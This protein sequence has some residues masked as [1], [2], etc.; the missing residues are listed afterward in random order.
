MSTNLAGT[1]KFGI[2]PENVFG[3][4][5]WVGGRYSVWSAVGGLPLSL[6]FGYEAFEEFL[7]GGRKIDD[8]VANTK[9][10][11]ANIP[12]MLGLIGFYNTFSSEIT[13][14]AI[15]PYCQALSKFPNH[16]QQLDME[17]NGKSV[18]LD[19]QFL[20]HSCSP[21]VFG[22]P[23]TNGQHGFYQLI[24]Q[25]RSIACEFIGFAKSQSEIKLEGEKHSNHEELMS[26][27]FAQVSFS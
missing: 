16:I 8:H 18:S 27:F 14:R 3:F 22:E 11:R 9:D 25:G 24:H 19:N 4:W 7:V 13:T 20:P 23:G 17:S 12:I 1:S 15:L 26:N 6:V 21:I 5:D 2:D 10:I